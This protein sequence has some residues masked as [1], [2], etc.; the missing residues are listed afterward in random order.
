M[1]QTRMTPLAT[2]IGLLLLVL[3]LLFA[4]GYFLLGWG[5]SRSDAPAVSNVATKTANSTPDTTSLPSTT[6]SSPT[7]VTKTVTSPFSPSPTAP[8]TTP[9]VEPREDPVPMPPDTPPAP[10]PS[11]RDC[12]EHTY[13][14]TDVTSCPFARSTG[15]TLGN[16]PPEIGYVTIAVYSPVTDEF[17]D[18]ACQRIA[19]PNTWD[20][21]GGSN[22]KVRIHGSA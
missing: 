18:M 3:I 14:L 15:Y 5:T 9:P 4:A 22:A 13:A 7:V 12:G 1:Q 2:I 6:S 16:P 10:Q 11:G 20:C 19:D 8:H 21:L 17:Y